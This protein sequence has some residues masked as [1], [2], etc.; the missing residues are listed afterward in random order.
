M[1]GE[2]QYTKLSRFL[3]LVL[4]HKPEKIGISLDAKGWA[5][6]NELIAK[7]SSFGK[8]IDFETLEHVVEI[9]NKQRYS[10]NTDKSKIRANQG[11]SIEIELGYI[12][13]PPPKI[14][15]HGTGNKYVNSIYKTGIQKRNRHHVHL[16][17]DIETAIDVGQRHGMPYVFEVLA[18]EMVKDGFTFYKSENGVWLTDHVPVKYLRKCEQ[19]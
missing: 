18:E 16:S 17:M 3:S 2:K 8:H 6:V 5:D 19:Q 13:E 10:F 15:Y 4:R 1:K 9:D 11:H 12:P 14:L 7:M